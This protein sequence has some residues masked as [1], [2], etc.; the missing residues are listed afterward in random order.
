MNSITVPPPSSLSYPHVRSV[1][2]LEEACATLSKQY[3]DC[4]VVK[5]DT[6]ALASD[7]TDE[8]TTKEFPDQ[9]PK[10]GFVSLVGSVTRDSFNMI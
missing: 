2:S 7:G 8:S 9:K 10:H 4:D 5:L 6:A 1:T 3:E